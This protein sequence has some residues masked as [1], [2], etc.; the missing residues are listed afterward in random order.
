MSTGMIAEILPMATEH[1]QA[2]RLMAESRRLIG[3]RMARLL[4]LFLP[5]LLFPAVRMAL[6]EEQW[7]ILFSLLV[8]LLLIVYVG[9]AG[10]LSYQLRA[11]TLVVALELLIGAEVAAHGLIVD[12]L[13]YAILAMILA[14]TLL[15]VW[16]GIGIFLANL[17]GMVAAA[18]LTQNGI[19]DVSDPLLLEYLAGN[20]WLWVTIKFVILLPLMVMPFLWLLEDTS[21]SLGQQRDLSRALRQEQQLLTRRIATRRQALETSLKISA[22]LATLLNVDLLVDEVVQQIHR[23][24]NYY[25]VQIYLLHKTKPVLELRGATG[26]AGK[27]LLARGHAVELGEGMVGRAARERE[28]LL[29]SDVRREPHW[30]PN[31]L[32]PDTRAEIAIPIVA[33]EDLIGVLDV[34]HDLL[35]GL[36]ADDLVVLQTIANQVAIAVQNATL[37]QRAQRRAETVAMVNRVVTTIR[38]ES[39]LDQVLKMTVKQ[40][41]ELVS[42]REAQ[43]ILSL[44]KED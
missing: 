9:L 28:L 39:D 12:A 15:D 1:P 2:R 5:V 3:Q 30:L 27:E 22:N 29:A 16:V 37:F 32:L 13:P 43:I 41:G 14:T 4:A 21:H 31:E 44:D 10:H 18:S 20:L 17:A 7:P 35:E 11:V 24:F 42:A 23:S 34:Q 40:M 6:L 8:S 38:H 25:H 36:T 33:G 26:V 19:I